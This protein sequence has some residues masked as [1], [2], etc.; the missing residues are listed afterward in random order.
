MENILPQ[1][2]DWL[3]D[4]GRELD[5]EEERLTEKAE[6]IKGYRKAIGIAKELLSENE[7]LKVEI[8]DLRQQ[9]QNEK[10]AR[11]KVEVQM[12]EMSKL[13]AN[14]VRK[15]SQDEVLKAVRTFVNK[16][17]QKTSKKRTLIKEMVLDFTFANG[18][19]LPFDLA[20]AVHALDDEQAEA[21]V[22]VNV[23]A[24]GIN[25]QQANNVRR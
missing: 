13:S 23:G 9:L 14:V 21:P 6:Q 7:D 15:S 2:E 16:S 24:G 1:F 10:E 5:R 22:T 20:Q 3:C 4:A 19:S 17:K 11:T 8:S 12:N 18:I 25:V